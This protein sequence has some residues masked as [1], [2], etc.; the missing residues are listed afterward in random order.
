MGLASRHVPADRGAADLAAEWTPAREY[1]QFVDVRDA[2]DA[3]Q[4]ALGVPLAGHYRMLLCAPASPPL[5][6]AWS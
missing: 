5:S 2:A 4:R 3:V 1:G 6:R